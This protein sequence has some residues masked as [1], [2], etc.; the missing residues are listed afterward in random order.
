M[1]VIKNGIISVTPK[2]PLQKA[3]ELEI[4]FALLDIV[5]VYG[6]LMVEIG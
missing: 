6:E 2:I 3:R 4:S 5:E 1:I